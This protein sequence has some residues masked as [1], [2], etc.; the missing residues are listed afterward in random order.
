[1]SCLEVSQD[2]D[3]PGVLSKS[4]RLAL[5]ELRVNVRGTSLTSRFS[6]GFRTQ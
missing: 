6:M 2:S 1:M 3:W 5:S 4:R